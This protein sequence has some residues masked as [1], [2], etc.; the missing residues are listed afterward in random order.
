MFA[1]KE[2]LERSSISNLSG[3]LGRVNRYTQKL[4]PYTHKYTTIIIVSLSG[5]LHV[6]FASKGFDIHEVHFSSKKN[7]TT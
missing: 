5:W 3:K 7:F 2:S 1:E 6:N 4:P